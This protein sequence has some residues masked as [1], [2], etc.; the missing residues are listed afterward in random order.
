M[1]RVRVYAKIIDEVEILL[2]APPRVSESDRSEKKYSTNNFKKYSNMQR[3]LKTAKCISMDALRYR[4]HIRNNVNYLLE[5]YLQLHSNGWNSS[6][7]DV[8]ILEIL[9]CTFFLNLL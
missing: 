7:F 4:F 1:Y 8:N 3:E 2:L 6:S 5:H 9:Y